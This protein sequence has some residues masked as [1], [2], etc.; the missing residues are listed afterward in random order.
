M[1]TSTRRWTRWLW[2]PVGALLLATALGLWRPVTV[3]YLLWRHRHDHDSFN[4]LLPTLCELGPRSREPVL[5]AFDAHDRGDD[6][7][8]FRVAVVHTL[9]CLRYQQVAAEIE[10]GAFEHVRYADVPMDQA[11]VDAIVAAYASEPDPALRDEMM[12]YLGE[13]DFRSRFTIFAGFIDSD[14]EIPDPWFPP[15]GIDPHLLGVDEVIRADWCE[16]L[17]PVYRS[18]LD[19]S[20]PQASA[21]DRF[22]LGSVVRQLVVA[23]CSEDDPEQVAAYLCAFGRPLPAYGPDGARGRV[24]PWWGLEMIAQGAGD[25][26]VK[27]WR[28]LEP[29]V[30][31]SLSEENRVFYEHLRTSDQVP[32]ALIDEAN[33]L[34]RKRWLR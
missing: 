26:R 9:R 25:H 15:P 23:D 5:R 4:R 30:Q 18:L 11:A 2:L 33:A 8:A 28:Y 3:Q 12:V 14:H 6:V 27:Q 7:A 22:E 13:L 29:V 19:G 1:G 10:S 21:Y 32:A 31:C 24:E 34:V 16:Q 17:A 20:G